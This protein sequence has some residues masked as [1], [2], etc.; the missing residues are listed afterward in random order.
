MYTIGCHICI[1]SNEIGGA[2]TGRSI[3]QAFLQ[4]GEFDV[5]NL[6]L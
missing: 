5:V 3:K 1:C 2:P 6:S 4:D